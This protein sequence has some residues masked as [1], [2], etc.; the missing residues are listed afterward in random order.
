[1]VAMFSALVLCRKM[2]RVFSNRGKLE[3]YYE[4][5]TLAFKLKKALIQLF[6]KTGKDQIEQNRWLNFGKAEKDCKCRT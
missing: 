5:T 4:C 2:I 6:I 1:M 3:F